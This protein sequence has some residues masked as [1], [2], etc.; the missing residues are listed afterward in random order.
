MSD[1][2][3]NLKSIFVID[4]S[5]GKKKVKPPKKEKEPEGKPETQAP[6]YVTAPPGVEGEVSQKFVDILFKAMERN[7]MEGFDYIEFKQSLNN[8][9]KMGMEE[10]M[11]FKSAYAAAQPMGAEK[12]KLINSAQHYMDVLKKEEAKFH[13][14]L[15]NQKEKQIQG[16]A[17]KIESLQNMITDKESRISQMQQEILAH[18]KE[19]ATVEQTLK[20]AAVKVAKTKEDFIL[21]YQQLYQQIEKDLHNIKQYIA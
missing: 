6:A 4:A 8:L 18:K 1:L 14:A 2:F 20:S 12:S 5:E 11:Q 19:L 3:K 7:N 15:A 16:T 13:Q 17:S 10:E 9:S 21:S